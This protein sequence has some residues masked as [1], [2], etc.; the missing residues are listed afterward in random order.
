MANQAVKHGPINIGCVSGYSGDR[1]DAL[2]Q[3]LDGPIQVDAI[4]GDYLAEMNLAWRKAEAEAGLTSG[5]DPTFINCLRYAS[6]QLG[7]RLASGTFPKI[8]VNAGALNPAR[9]ATD[10]RSYLQDQY[11]DR[12]A[13]LKVAYVTGDDISNL[14]QESGVSKQITHFNDKSTLDQCD[15]EPLIANAYIGQAGFVEALRAGVDIVLAGRA[16]DAGSVQ[17]LCTWWY[18]W[19]D[20]DYDQHATALIAGHLIECGNYVTGGNFAGFKSVRNYYDIAYPIA[21]IYD[22]GHCVITKQPGQNGIVTI[23]T[24]RS[25]LLYEIQGRYYYNPDVIAD[26]SQVQ[27]SQQGQDEV[28]VSGMTGL[29]PPPHLKVAML[30]KAGF[31]SEMQVYAIGI[32][33]IEKFD[34]FELQT[35]LM[36]DK[37]A[38]ATGESLTVLDMQHIGTCPPNPQSED[39]ATTTIRIFAQSKTELPLKPNNFMYPIMQNL[40]QAFP[41]FTPNLEYPRT[42]L[43]RP[44][45]EY[46]PGLID[47]RLVNLSV[48]VDDQAPKTIQHFVPPEVSQPVQENYESTQPREMSSFGKTITIPLGHQVFARSGDKGPNVSVGFFPQGD[49]QEEWD[50]LRSF[51]TTDRLM[52]LLGK[53]ASEVKRSERV[54]FPNIRAVHFVLFGMLGGGVTNT[55]RADALGKGIAEYL[56]IKPV[57]YPVKLYRGIEHRI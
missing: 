53:D 23:D 8:V 29:P 35:R 48:T 4:V 6:E 22:D 38:K 19:K 31:Q 15:F 28:H 49:S 50:W 26:L 57:P 39:E 42:T 44:Y 3:M 12:G 25:Q 14:V 54:E 52:Q 18:D 43:P 7:A 46:F 34:T 51:L 11:G 5:E 33:S 55:K 13:S 30:A 47:R 36:L 9:L 41:G 32:D 45:M 27:V 16:T 1:I 24:I 56:R 21:R 2:A 37:V 40:G 17:S 20:G 10:L